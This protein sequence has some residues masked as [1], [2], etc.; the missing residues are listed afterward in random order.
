[1]P[2][3]F[4]TRDN[5]AA[6][7]HPF[8]KSRSERVNYIEQLMA[9][10]IWSYETTRPLQRAL[11]E[12]WGLMPATIR[13][14][15]SEAG[16]RLAA[17]AS[18]HA[19]EAAARSLEKLFEILESKPEFPGDR[20]AQV[21]AIK[22]AFELSGTKDTPGGAPRGPVTITFGSIATPAPDADPAE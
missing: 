16:R 20:G 15:S 12:A 21:Q 6:L 17:N 10:W 2:K 4:W 9:D 3:G 8:L 18:Q 7:K 5:V 11:A 19:P 1:M 13:D 22:L 14:Y